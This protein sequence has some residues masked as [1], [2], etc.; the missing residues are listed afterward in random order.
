MLMSAVLVAFLTREKNDFFS[1]CRS[2]NLRTQKT[3]KGY[4]PRK[5]EM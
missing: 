4:K 1:S 3:S 5:N 2:S